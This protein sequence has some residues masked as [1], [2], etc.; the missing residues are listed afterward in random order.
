MQELEIKIF[1]LMNVEYEDVLTKI[2]K[3]VDE[4]DIE[5]YMTANPFKQKHQKEALE[6]EV[7]EKLEK[8]VEKEISNWLK[9]DLKREINSF[10][11]ELENQLGQDIDIFYEN[12]DGFR[13]EISGVKNPK[14]ISGFER[15]SATILGTIIGGPMYGVLGASLGL[16]EIAKRSAVT[17]GASAVGGAIVAFTPIGIATITTAASIAIVSAGILQLATGGKALTNKYKKQLKNSF[18]EK[19]KDSKEEDCKKYAERVA[20][21]VREKFS[22]VSQALDNEIQIEHSKIE[23]LKKNKENS[24]QE[25]ENKILKLNQCVDELTQISKLL[26]ELE[27]EIS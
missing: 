8:F 26:T 23:T 18:V 20:G 3:F 5:N 22:L 19:L 9:D 25:R 15:V 16:G 6:K 24:E 1:D 21:D 12:L 27:R 4:M 13:Y 2:P 11:D 10:V 7:V 17:M 14:D